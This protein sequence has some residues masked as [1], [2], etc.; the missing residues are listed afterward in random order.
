MVLLQLA[1]TLERRHP[2]MEGES[3]EVGG[4]H[5]HPGINVAESGA[6]SKLASYG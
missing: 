4:I 5:F 2:K 1:D 6:S 3:V